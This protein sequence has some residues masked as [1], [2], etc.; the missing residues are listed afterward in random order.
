LYE[1][2]LCVQKNVINLQPQANCGEN[3][4]TAAV[5]NMHTGRSSTANRRPAA[6]KYTSNK[7]QAKTLGAAGIQS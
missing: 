3:V 5:N 6:Q 1:T 2:C 7:L 4:I